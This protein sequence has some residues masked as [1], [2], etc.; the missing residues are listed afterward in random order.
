M[1]KIS[2]AL[3]I[4]CVSSAA[5]ASQV[6]EIMT[7]QSTAATPSQVTKT[8]PIV[9][10]TPNESNNINNF[11]LEISNLENR[12]V[13][14]SFRCMSSLKNSGFISSSQFDYSNIFTPYSK[15]YLGFHQFYLYALFDR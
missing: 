12:C 11:N 9:K 3:A 2:L 14:L 1:K 15:L 13:P 10:T 7:I 4:L 6:T 8:M 5:M